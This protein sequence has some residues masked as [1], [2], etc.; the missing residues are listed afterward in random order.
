M[1]AHV[2]NL[3]YQYIRIKVHYPIKIDKSKAILEKL[4]SII[5]PISIKLNKFRRTTA[6]SFII[7]VITQISPTNRT[8]IDRSFRHH[9]TSQG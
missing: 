5:I 8:H 2:R 4:H 7:D 9:N 3:Q 1:Y 6:S